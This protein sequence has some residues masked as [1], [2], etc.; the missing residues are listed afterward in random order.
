MNVK[1]KEVL[2]VSLKKAIMGVG[3]SGAVIAMFHNQEDFKHWPGIVK[4]ASVVAITAAW[5]EGWYWWPRIM[6]WAS[7]SD[8]GVPP[9]EKP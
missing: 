4:I 1:L 2:V 9:V 8:M 7:T 5:S 3:T 6:A